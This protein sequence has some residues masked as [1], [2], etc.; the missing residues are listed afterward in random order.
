MLQAR[1]ELES[2]ELH[3]P[4]NAR[5]QLGVMTWMSVGVGSKTTG[6]RYRFLAGLMPSNASWVCVPRPPRQGHAFALLANE[7][8]I[9]SLLQNATARDV[10]AKLQNPQ[11]VRCWSITSAGNALDS[12]IPFWRLI[13]ARFEQTCAPQYGKCWPC[14]A[15]HLSNMSAVFCPIFWRM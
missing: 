13:Q 8:D 10:F 15:C 2:R 1:L 5:G 4:L 3:E 6:L 14:C 12:L 7:P 11:A 9:A